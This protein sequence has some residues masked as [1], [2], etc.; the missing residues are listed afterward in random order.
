[1]RYFTA[2]LVAIGM[3]VLV[4]VILIKAL[5]GH[6]P[7]QQI[8]F[9][10]YATT[11][12]VVRMTID[13]PVNADSEHNEVQISVSNSEAE[14]QIM[15]GYQGS[16]KT[17]KTYDSNQDAYQSFLHALTLA[18]FTKGNS[19]P[20]LSDERGYC[21]QGSR[22][23]FELVQGADTIER[24]WSTACGS[25]GTYGGNRTLTR[26]LFQ[27]QIPDFDELTGDVQL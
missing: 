25:Q 12:A 2:F 20:K 3:I 10:S 4:V 7:K 5:G 11:D 26:Q 13:G 14:I 9:N 1:M 24:Y 27:A 19:D 17:D 23:V 18:G 6:A 15:K 16:V 8:D 22:Y 21:P